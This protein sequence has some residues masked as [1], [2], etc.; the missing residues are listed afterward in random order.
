MAAIC[1]GARPC[2]SSRTI[3]CDD[4]ARL[5]RAGTGQHQA[6]AAQVVHGLE[7]GGVEGVGHGAG[8]RKGAGDDSGG[9]ASS[10]TIPAWFDFDSGAGCWSRCACRGCLRWRRTRRNGSTATGPGHWCS[11]RWPC[12]GRPNRRGWTLPITSSMRSR[13]PSPRRP[14]CPAPTRKPPPGWP[15]HSRTQRSA[16]LTDLHQGRVDPRQLQ[17]DF[18]PPARGGLR[19]SRPVEGR[20]GPR[21]IRRGRPAA[22]PSLPQYAQLRQALARYRA[23]ADDPAWQTPL[24]PLPR[25]RQARSGKLVPGASWAGLAQLSQRLAALGDLAAVPSAPPAR[26][27]AS[28]VD[29]VRAFQR[30]HG[31]T[32]DGVIGPATLGALEVGAGAARATDRADAGAPALDAAVPGAAHGRHQPARVRAARLRSGRRPHPG[33]R[34]DEGRRRQGA[35]HAHADVRRG[36]ALHRVQPVLE[37]AAVD[38]A[39]RDR[40][41][42][43][44]RPGLL[45]A[46]GAASSSAPAAAPTPS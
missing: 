22:T 14:R 27:D 12:S 13:G 41:A 31:L 23:L 1:A 6:G 2:C 35:G 8:A 3:L 21:R 45:R 7:L 16:Y 39:R 43:A 26:Y 25:P 17:Q 19:R 4:H 24:P 38:R 33:T 28:L 36:H 34:D 9:P 20:G 29:A 10:G 32:D 15:Q 40:A 18:R 11:R 46:P 30:R 37:R 42:P 44:S 5:A